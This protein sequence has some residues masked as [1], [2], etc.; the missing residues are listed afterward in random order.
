M[1]LGDGL[2]V[3]PLVNILNKTQS[4]IRSFTLESGPPGDENECSVLR[5]RI[6]R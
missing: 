3:N 6:T 4:V 5:H 1:E 2:V